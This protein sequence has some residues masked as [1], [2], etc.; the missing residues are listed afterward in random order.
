M[1]RKGSVVGSV[2]DSGAWP[3]SGLGLGL[4]LGFDRFCDQIFDYLK[5]LLYCQVWRLRRRARTPISGAV[6]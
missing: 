2:Y 4:G 6:G 1:V 3:D 5:D